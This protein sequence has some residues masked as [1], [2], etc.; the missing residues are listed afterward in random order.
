MIIAL[1]F[2]SG[3]QHAISQKIFSFWGHIRVQHYEPDKVAI[4]EE[5]PIDKNDTVA[6]LKKTV[7]GIRSVQ[8]YATKNAILKTAESIE[9]VL[10]KGIDS[11][12]DTMRMSS[13]LKEGRWMQFPD[14][15]Y[16]NEIVLSTYT[17]NQLNLKVNESILIYFIQNDGSAPRA[18]K[19]NICGIYK[20][21]IEDYDKMIALGDLR[22]I[23]RLN[24]WSPNSIGGYE[25]FLEDHEM[26]DG[27]NEAVFT[28]LPVL[29]NSR[30][31]KEIYPNIFDWLSLQD[32]TIAIVLIIMIIVAILNLITCLIILVLER[33][34]MVGVLKAIGAPDGMIQKIFLYHGGV[35]TLT[36]I[37]L[38]NILAFTLIFLQKRYGLIS[39]PEE[40]YY[41]SKA[42]V[43]VIPWQIMAVNAGTFLICMAVLLIPTYIIR[44]IEPVRAIQFK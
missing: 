17:A 1:A 25:I 6:G 11:S 19:L 15:G 35:I 24:N 3:F 10:F 7:P 39:L 42:E 21:G 38:G 23:Q 28:E 41:I 37:I 4:A 18:R 5:Y 30:T 44:R 22:L 36:G 12:Y 2:T 16:S 33:T 14:S 13:F 34:R 29:W 26:I 27:V 31:I 40:M 8:P 43:K 32:K 9:G 20:T